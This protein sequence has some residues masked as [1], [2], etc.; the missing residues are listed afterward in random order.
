[1]S[2][3]RPQPMTRIELVQASADQLRVQPCT[4]PGVL[5]A[6]AIAFLRPVPF[7][8]VQV[9]NVHADNPS[10]RRAPNTAVTSGTR[11]R[12]PLVTLP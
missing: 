1:M 12:V 8:A 11:C 10:R 9:E 5:A 7:V 4:D 6:P 3:V 2:V